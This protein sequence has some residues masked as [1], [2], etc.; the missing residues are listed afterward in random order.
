MIAELAAGSQEEPER[1]RA[2]RFTEEERRLAYVGCTRARE[3]LTITFAHSY[4]R[5]EAQP[6]PFLAELQCADANAWMVDEESDAGV[7]LPLDVARA[8]RQQ[9]LA[10]LGVSGRP[11]LPYLVAE[12]DVAGDVLGTV[13]AAQWT[14]SQVAGGVPIR[15][16]ELPRPFIDESTLAVSFS[17]IE[18]YR[19]CPR[20]FFYG[21]VLHVDAPARG[22]S[23]TLGSKIHDALRDLNTQWMATGTPPED[24]Q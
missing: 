15:F 5:R 23:T 19:T 11:V 20:Q 17:G 7:M 21:H 13:L 16:R 22:A 18:G 6:S 2:R 3:R 9:A 12:D 4:D 10:A 1:E 8:V 14:A 24:E